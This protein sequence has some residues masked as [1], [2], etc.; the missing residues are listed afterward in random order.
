MGFYYEFNNHDYFFSALEAKA[1][2]QFNGGRMLN[3]IGQFLYSTLHSFVSS[4]FQFSYS[5]PF[6]GLVVG[7]RP[8]SNAEQEGT[9][10]TGDL[11]LIK[12]TL[13]G[14][15]RPYV[16]YTVLKGVSSENN[17]TYSPKEIQRKSDLRRRLINTYFSHLCD[18]THHIIQKLREESFASVLKFSDLKEHPFVQLP[19]KYLRDDI[20][21]VN[22]TPSSVTGVKRNIPEI[23]RVLFV[24]Q[25]L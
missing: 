19:D 15:Y 25:D 8:S 21:V 14:T 9:I 7:T 23:G 22:F 5:K 18:L 10:C 4:K 2:D 6:Y 16:S 13:N 11:S 12:V 1:S 20:E 17:N 3:C 24:L